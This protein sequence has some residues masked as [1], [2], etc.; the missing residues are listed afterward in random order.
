MLWV[1]GLDS[2]SDRPVGSIPTSPAQ[3]FEC[4]H[5]CKLNRDACRRWKPTQ[6]AF[7]TLMPSSYR[8][9]GESGL[10][11]LVWTQKIAG[12]NPAPPTSQKQ[13]VLT[14]QPMPGAN[15][16]GTGLPSGSTGPG[17]AATGRRTRRRVTPTPFAW[18]PTAGNANETQM[19][20]CLPSKQVV[21]GSNPVVRSPAMPR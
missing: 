12:S 17:D 13:G 14:D 18:R 2:K 20:E 19:A 4:L 7:S 1:S 6:R 16:S 15:S 5:I 9:V 21:A 10:P 11:R 3:H 8:S